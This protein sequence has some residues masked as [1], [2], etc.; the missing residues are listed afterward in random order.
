ML[1]RLKKS[2]SLKR[3]AAVCGILF[4]LGLMGI[5]CVASANFFVGRYAVPYIFTDAGQLPQ[6]DAILVLGA[7]VEESGRPSATLRQRLDNALILYNEG[8]ADRIILSG[9]HGQKDYDEVN[10]M[11]DYMMERGVPREVLFLDHA[12]FNT[13]DS[14]YRA[15]DIFQVE[16]LLICT[17]RFHIDRSVYI[18]RRM[19]IDA[20]G[21]PQESWLGYYR[22]L[23]GVREGLATVKALWDVEITKRKPRFLGEPIP[24]SG[25]GLAT[26]G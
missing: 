10:A 21:Y 22:R 19:G 25:C 20:Y 2:K 14:M 13:Y 12:G 1:N 26:E 4:L 11:K 16:S 8:K 24:I 15:R 5:S 9:D 18:A 6:A 23:Y 7:F 3:F 17:Q